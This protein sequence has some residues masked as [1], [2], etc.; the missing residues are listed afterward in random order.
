ME[1]KGNKEK[2]NEGKWKMGKE[3]ME[4]V[5]ERIRV[6]GIESIRVVDE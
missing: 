3:K 1:E 2:K 6:R 4:V 5:D